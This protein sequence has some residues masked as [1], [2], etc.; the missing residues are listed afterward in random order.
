M[1]KVLFDDE[2]ERAAPKEVRGLLKLSGLK[3]G[4]VLDVACGTGRHSAAFAAKGFE[5]TGID[6]SAAYL[7][8]A[9]LRL[10]AAGLSAKFDV[11]EISDLQA[12]RGRFDLVV[13]LF[14]SF[15]YLSTAAKNEAS[16]RQMAA[17]LKPGGFLAI[18]LL[19][20]E[21]LL[22]IFTPQDAQSVDGGWLTQERR[23]NKDGRRL[24]TRATWD[25]KGRRKA[26]D[27]DFQTYTRPELAALFKRAG[28]RK[29]RAFGDFNGQ[30][31]SVGDRLLMIGSKP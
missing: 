19:P 13:N 9:R 2:K 24:H 26:R 18:E 11:A 12:Y 25:L 23:W 31:F 21:S 30:P 7:R 16:L 3:K 22:E 1:A 8:K 28:L 29:I 5:V 10:R 14:T 17:C 20:H 4:S 27:S 15:G 6:V